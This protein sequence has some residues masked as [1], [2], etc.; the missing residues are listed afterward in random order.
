MFHNSKSLKS[1]IPALLSLL[2]G[3][4]IAN[5]YLEWLRSQTGLSSVVGIILVYVY[6]SIF[7]SAIVYQLFFKFGLSR[8]ACYD[9]KWRLFWISFSLILGIWLSIAIPLEFP[10]QTNNLD[11]KIVATGEKNPQSNGSEVWLSRLVLPNGDVVPVENFQAGKGWEIR[12]G[13]WFSFF[14]EEPLIWSGSVDSAQLVFVSHP[15]SGMVEIWLNEQYQKLDLYDPAGKEVVVDLTP[16]AQSAPPVGRYFLFILGSGVGIGLVIFLMGIWI[17]NLVAAR[18]GNWTANS[19]RLGFWKYSLIAFAGL[20]GYWLIFFPGILASDVV[21][22]WGQ[23]LKFQI[24][25]AHPAAHTLY[26]W[27]LT[28]VWNSPAIVALFQ[29]IVF[30]LIVG[31][32]LFFFE[33]LNAPQGLLWLIALLFGINPLNAVNII[34]LWKDTIFSA[35]FLLLFYFQLKIIWSNG[36]WLHSLKNASLLFMSMLGLA[37]FRHNGLYIVVGIS[38]GLL[39]FYYRYRYR[40]IFIL[41]LLLA[42]QT[43]ITGPFY[44]L[45]GVEKINKSRFYNSYIAYYLGYY[46]SSERS[47]LNSEQIDFLDKI[48]PVSTNWY[49]DKYCIISIGFNMDIINDIDQN[50]INLLIQITKRY[51]FKSIDMV[52]THGSLVWKIRNLDAY[53]WLYHEPLNEVYIFPLEWG[54]RI[55]KQSFAPS[56][57]KIIG[58]IL[59]QGRI[60][61]AINWLFFRP[62]IYLYFSTFV[63]FLAAFRNQWGSLL[64]LFFPILFQSASMLILLPCQD[65]RYQYPIYVFSL[66][67]FPLVFIEKPDSLNRTSKS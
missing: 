23:M 44:Q 9:K 32:I 22:Q 62:A 45:I 17:D 66:V 12:E 26:F 11:L 39:I 53:V 38:I 27:L 29:I 30:S 8:I 54:P 34:S 2:V 28:R 15:W 4:L 19:K 61:N 52:F 20:C 65:F 14:S 5:P 7:F 36:I 58:D 51:P 40:L 6:A 24:N 42:A 10:K 60:N 16:P 41:L 21:D 33:E 55:E 49:F 63:I 3:M 47:L 59:S 48:Y 57:A 18:S 56:L 13:L 35:C 43:I 46:L 31:K 1:Y 37:L 25:D 67:V 50:A 64:S